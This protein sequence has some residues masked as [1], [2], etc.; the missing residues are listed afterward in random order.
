MARRFTKYPSNYVR[1]S[2][3]ISTGELDAIVN[4]YLN[5]GAT[6]SLIVAELKG[7]YGLE[8]AKEIADMVDAKRSGTDIKAS[9]DGEYAPYKSAHW[10]AIAEFSDGTTL[11]FTKPYTAN[12]NYEMEEEQQYSIESELLRRAA[13]TGKEVTFY[14]VNFVG[15]E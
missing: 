14:T 8:K 7:D 5:S 3:E 2:R 6:W 4:E 12:G 15:E 13:N 9:T 11:E 1:A 10:E